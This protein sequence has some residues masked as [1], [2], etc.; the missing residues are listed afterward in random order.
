MCILGILATSVAR[1]IPKIAG[2][3]WWSLDS[4]GL[5]TLSIFKLGRPTH[6][7]IV[8]PA[9]QRSIC[10]KSVRG[11]GVVSQVQR[12]EEDNRKYQ[13]ATPLVSAIRRLLRL[14]CP[15][16]VCYRERFYNRV[17]MERVRICDLS[18]YRP[19]RRRYGIPP[20]ERIGFFSLLEPWLHK[21]GLHWP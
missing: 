16:L 20:E 8:L 1:K 13:L 9:S 12:V 17:G 15:Q 4:N 18:Q 19:R 5:V 14:L 2:K 3:S 11:C 21:R 10:C 7:H 6:K